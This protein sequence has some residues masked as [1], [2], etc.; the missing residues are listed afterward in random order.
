MTALSIKLLSKS[1]GSQVVLDNLDLEIN[2]GQIFGLIGP[3]GAGKT[4]T[5]NC[6]ADLL[7][8]NS[9]KIEIFGQDLVSN[10][11]EVKKNVGILFENT[12][13]L[14]EYLKG[15]EQLQFVGEIY[16]LDKTTIETRIYELFEYFNLEIFRWKSVSEYSKGMRKKLALAS[17]LLYNPDLI[18]MDE[19][20]DG[21]D[22]LTVKKVKELIKTLKKNG[23]TILIT[24]H[25]LSYIEDIT[26]EVA[27]IDNGKIVFQSPTKEIR[28][29]F[30]NSTTNENYESLEEVF[31]DLTTEGGIQENVLSW[32]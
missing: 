9:G 6:I 22:T 4:T 19:P 23:K 11:I 12:E 2:Q 7:N 31:L 32:L 1:F 28:T 30:K 25:I 5:I 10:R 18:I 27:I 21:L 14:F 16:G 13:S 26:D 29:K 20:F 17:I 15:E 8:F 24:S 3:N